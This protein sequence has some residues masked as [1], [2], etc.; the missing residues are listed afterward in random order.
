MSRARMRTTQ[1]ARAAYKAGAAWSLGQSLIDPP[2][3]S[4]GGFLNKHILAWAWN[5]LKVAFT[6]RHRFLTYEGSPASKPGI[7]PLPTDCKV[8]LV[9]DWGSGTESAYRV[10]DH[11]RDM[12]KPD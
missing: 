11:V 10:I 5:Y 6:S 2:P 9:G 1:D 7:F 3:R 12:Q 8:A 4:V